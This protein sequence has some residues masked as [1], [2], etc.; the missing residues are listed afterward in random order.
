MSFMSN[1]HLEFLEEEGN[2]AVSEQTPRPNRY[3]F[4]DG[5]GRETL[6]IDGTLSTEPEE[7]LTMDSGRASMTTAFN[8]RS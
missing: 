2:T 4:E 7:S 8:A 3:M 5:R 1:A 6:L